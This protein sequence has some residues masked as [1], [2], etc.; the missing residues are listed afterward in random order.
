MAKLMARTGGS[1]ERLGTRSKWRVESAVGESDDCCDKMVMMT[2][3]FAT[4]FIT[5]SPLVVITGLS[6]SPEH[7]GRLGYD[8]FADIETRMHGTQMYVAVVVVLVV[9][10]LLLLVVVIGSRTTRSPTRLRREFIAH[11]YT[12][13]C[14]C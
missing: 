10:L 8:A 3:V 2:L 12:C 4:T 11:K 5:A 9:V 6:K 7:A 13:S 14:S 1:F